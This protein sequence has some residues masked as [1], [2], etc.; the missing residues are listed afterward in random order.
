MSF[1][2]RRAI[3]FL[4]SISGAIAAPLFYISDSDKWPL[5]LFMYP[6]PIDHGAGILG[7]LELNSDIKICV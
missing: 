4:K 6:D 2:P 3:H 5:E 1:T 7:M